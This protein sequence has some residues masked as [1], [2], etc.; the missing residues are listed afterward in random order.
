[1]TT[2][3]SHDQFNTTI[4]GLDDRYRGVRGSRDVVFLNA[5]DLASRGLRDGDAVDVTSHFGSETRTL[6]GLR[7]LVYDVP[8]GCAAMY[9]PEANPLVAVDHTAAESRT[10]AYKH[11]SISVARSAT[12]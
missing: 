9:F 10:P 7:A 5:A 2:I 8:A 4:Y 11:V 1:M 3:R 12:R 6:R